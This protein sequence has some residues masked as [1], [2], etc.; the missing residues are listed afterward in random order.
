MSG[1]SITFAVIAAMV[2]LFITD[3]IPVAA[4]ALGAALMLYATG[5]LTL[6]RALEG[7]GD[8]TVLFIGS[9]FVVSASLEA[10]G[11]TTWVGQVLTRRA[12]R[13]P[14]RLLVLT[15]LLGSGLSALIGGGGAVA[16][17]M[18]VVIL[19]AVR[20]GQ[21]P[22]K[23]L[24][25]LAF[26]AH[27]GSMLVLTGS[28][29]NVLISNAKVD[30]GMAPLRY[31]DLTPIGLLLV[32]GTILITVLLGPAV[33]PTRVGRT[34]P[35]DLSRHGRLLAEQ[36]QLFDSL[37]R[38]Q[39]SERSPLIGMTRDALERENRPAMS[40]IV[41]RDHE[42]MRP[43]P[44]P[45]M[46]RPRREHVL[47]GD[48]VLLGGDPTEVMVYA[49]EKGL[50]RD[51]DKHIRE[52][53]F[54]AA[55]GYAEVVIPPRSALIGE[56]MFPGM[57][58]PGGALVVLAIQRRSEA[59]KS[60]EV[61]LA[62]GDTLLL[63]GNWAALDEHLSGPDVLVVDQPDTIRRQ[64]VKFGPAGVIALAVLAGMVL[65]LAT[66]LVP[67]VAAGLAAAWLLVALRVIKIDQAYRAINWTVLIMIAALMS[68]SA[69]ME[70]TGAANLMASALVH[71]MGEAS[72]FALLAGLFVVT[73]VLGQLISSTATALIVIP[74][75]ISAAHEIGMA[76]RTALITVAVA[77]A[78]SFLT[79]VAA[80]AN[81]MVQSPGAYRFTD[82]WRLG[83]PLTAWFFFVATFL[84]PLLWR[85]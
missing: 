78:A 43:L 31:F 33:L 76:P 83:V 23:V 55:Y 70:E 68:L 72:P 15:M 85:F 17:L 50:V 61:V 66:G 39:I 64:A 2:V 82:Y 8:S 41:P 73:A 71:L 29:V 24:I 52:D 38:Y 32:G 81:L 16:A 79:P 28:L 63:Q 75:A 19:V 49:Q 12:G 59:M 4:V 80:S 10:S 40:I 65:L 1:I 22:G 58:T 11:V 21:R 20:L 6:D 26:S 27:A 25:P 35:E 36:Y 44:V 57:I 9:L 46:V 42:S 48:A 34:V 69:A 62:A 14:K 53:L 67:R 56:V 7:F 47:P 37:D 77:A 54:N 84:V 5:V 45:G 30:M 18:P 60:G 51:E 74:V 13:N 3:L